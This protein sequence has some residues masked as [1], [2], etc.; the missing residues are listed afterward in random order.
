LITAQPGLVTHRE[1]ILQGRLVGLAQLVGA[2]TLGEAAALCK[3]EPGLLVLT[4]GD[5]QGRC[6]VCAPLRVGE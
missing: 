6:V 1:E 4:T 3:R 5:L 2:A